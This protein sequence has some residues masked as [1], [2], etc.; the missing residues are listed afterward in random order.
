M[1]LRSKLDLE[2][3]RNIRAN[4]DATLEVALVA[5][6][7]QIAADAAERAPKDTKF[8]AE[9]IHVTALDF[10]DYD[11]SRIAAM[12]E[13]AKAKAAGETPKGVKIGPNTEYKFF[14]EIRP[15]APKVVFVCVG[16]EHGINNELGIR[17]RQ[18]FLAAAVYENRGLLSAQVRTAMN[19]LSVRSVVTKPKSLK[20]AVNG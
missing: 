8:L 16:A 14:P 11:I 15:T 17:G 3:I 13:F 4:I 7:R 1:G 19:G 9:S 20:K 6:A 12:E 10:S 18:P 2:G 5:T